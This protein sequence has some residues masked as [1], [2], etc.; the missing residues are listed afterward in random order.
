[1][2]RMWSKGASLR[3]LG[4]F[5]GRYNIPALPACRILIPGSHLGATAE[6]TQRR[7]SVLVEPHVADAEAGLFAW[8]CRGVV[9]VLFCLH[10]LLVALMNLLQNSKEVPLRASDLGC[11]VAPADASY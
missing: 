5:G 3:W 9:L 8:L 1:M 10:P 11:C 7:D 2:A 6:P 4:P